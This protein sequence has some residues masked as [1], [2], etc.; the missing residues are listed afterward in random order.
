MENKVRVFDKE[1]GAYGFASVEELK[2]NQLA[3]INVEFYVNKCSRREELPMYK[4]V[5]VREVRKSNL[6]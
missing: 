4:L 2:N 1:R 5:K 6:K 3:V